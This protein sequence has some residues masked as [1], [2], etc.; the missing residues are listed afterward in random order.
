VVEQVVLLEMV[1]KVTV[2]LLETVKVFQTLLSLFICQHQT[3]I[4]QE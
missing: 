1:I 4:V 2:D 3:H